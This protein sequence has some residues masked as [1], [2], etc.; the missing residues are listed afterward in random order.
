M[1]W[2]IKTALSVAVSAHGVCPQRVP[3]YSFLLGEV[4]SGAMMV[5]H[6]A[7]F[8]T[9][10]HNSNKRSSQLRQIYCAL[11]VHKELDH[12]CV[13]QGCSFVE[14]SGLLAVDHINAS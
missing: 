13:V 2:G 4:P 6:R 8:P 10:K 14:G 9:A 5:M 3:S 12:L 7:N 1:Q 11:P